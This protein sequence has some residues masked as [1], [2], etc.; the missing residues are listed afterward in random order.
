[1]GLK[2][3]GPRS[4]DWEIS[5]VITSEGNIDFYYQG[6]GVNARWL[7]GHLLVKLRTALMNALND[8]GQMYRGCSPCDADKLMNRPVPKL[9]RV[10]Y[11]QIRKFF[12]AGDG[13][14]GDKCLCAVYKHLKRSLDIITSKE[15]Q[16]RFYADQW[17]PD[18]GY[19]YWNVTTGGFIGLSGAFMRSTTNEQ[20][21]T[22][23]HEITHMG[24][25]EGTADHGYWQGGYG[26]NAVY[27]DADGKVVEL[28]S[29]KRCNNASTIENFFRTYYLSD[30]NNR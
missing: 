29:T 1:M 22:L 8:L 17:Y 5:G 24:V 11:D 18:P 21:A 6:F 2:P 23:L 26:A 4:G 7:I 14:F 9:S 20:I 10:T 15:P 13:K 3:W 25:I 16:L 27:H 28:S 30:G 19:Y 12:D